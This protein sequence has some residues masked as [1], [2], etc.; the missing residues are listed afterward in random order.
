MW[1]NESPCKEVEI[2]VYV[3]SNFSVLW[4]TAW[5]P[6]SCTCENDSETTKFSNRADHASFWNWVTYSEERFFPG[7]FNFLKKP[8]LLRCFHLTT[9]IATNMFVTSHG[10][11]VRH[12]EE[13][14]YLL[15][16]NN[17]F[18]STRG[19]NFLFALALHICSSCTIRFGYLHSFSVSLFMI[20]L[21]FLRLF[22]F[23][24]RLMY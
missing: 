15:L 13:C 23:F 12:Q 21:E 5:N 9:N 14:I 10:V 3:T 11:I 24:N 17:R 18:H 6:L 1:V 22:V 4:H 8:Y 20:F 16:W 19:L 7:Y 2:T